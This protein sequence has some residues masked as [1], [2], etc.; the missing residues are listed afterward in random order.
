MLKPIQAKHV[1]N[2]YSNS[3]KVRSKY[4]NA[5]YLEVYNHG[6][7]EHSGE[8]VHQIWEILSVECFPQTPD[9]ILSGGQQVE[10]GNDC[11]FKLSTWSKKSTSHT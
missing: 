6:K 5:I 3:L 2:L 1:N 4:I 8:K 11:S 10:Q 9:L 7:Y